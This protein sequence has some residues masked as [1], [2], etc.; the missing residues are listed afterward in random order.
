MKSVLLALTTVFISVY[1]MA[2]AAGQFFPP[3]YKQFPF[4]EGDLLASRSSNGKYSINKVLKVDKVF[5]KKGGYIIFQS[6]KFTATEDDYLLVVSMSYGE[7]EFSSLEQARLAA[8]AGKWTI[9]FEH[10]P[11]RPPGA[12]EGQSL[13]GHAPV[14]ETELEGYRHWKEAFDKGMAGVF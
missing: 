10:I 7:S 11:N 9:H 3:E 13:V 1:V 4:N 8:V 12:A 14:T 5:I 6:Q 2:S